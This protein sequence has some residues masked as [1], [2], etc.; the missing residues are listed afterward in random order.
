MRNIL[1]ILVV[2]N[3]CFYSAFCQSPEGNASVYGIILKDNNQ[4]ITTSSFSVQNDSIRF[5]DVITDSA[6]T[7]STQDIAEIKIY[8]KSPNIW[9]RNPNADSTKPQTQPLLIKQD[10]FVRS[11]NAISAGILGMGGGLALNYDRLVWQNPKMFL[12][13]GMGVG[14][15]PLGISLPHYVT[16]N[17]GKKRGH[18]EVGIAGTY[19]TGKFQWT[20]ETTQLY[21]LAPVVGYRFQPSKGF[22]FR[23][24]LCPMINIYDPQNL[25]RIPVLPYTGFDVGYSF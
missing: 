9:E 6:Q 1:L 12:S 5:V 22:Y 24:H 17:I 11:K 20:T 13:A 8:R 21:L 2:W 14:M 3:S 4:E 15:V 10:S 25:I 23:V 7:L 19:I 18:L 16:A